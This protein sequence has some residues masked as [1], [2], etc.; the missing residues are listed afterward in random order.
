MCAWLVITVVVVVALRLFRFRFV[1]ISHSN[2]VAYF[3][4][5]DKLL[6]C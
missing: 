4:D 2:F 3:W 5:A 1:V 6:F